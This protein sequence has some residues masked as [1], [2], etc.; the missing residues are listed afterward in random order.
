MIKKPSDAHNLQLLLLY[1]AD[2]RSGQSETSAVAKFQ[3]AMSLVPE[4]QLAAKICTGH[5]QT[6]LV[7]LHS[8]AGVGLCHRT[9]YVP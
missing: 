2:H 7:H 6:C 5:T 1:P 4:C 3:P 8:T 9:S